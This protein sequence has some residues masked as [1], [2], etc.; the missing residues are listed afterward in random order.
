MWVMVLLADADQTSVSFRNA[1][2]L[3]LAISG[4]WLVTLV[5]AL[6]RHGKAA[7]WALL[8]APFILSLPTMIW[9]LSR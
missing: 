3:S 6:I 4:L 2:L 5:A 9:L 7:L 1:I 8:G